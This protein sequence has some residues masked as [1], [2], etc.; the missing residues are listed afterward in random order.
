MKLFDFVD[1]GY[2]LNL[3][4]R[5]DRR[6]QFEAHFHEMGLL[7]GIHRHPATHVL[8]LISSRTGD[9]FTYEQRLQIKDKD[10]AAHACWVSHSEVIKLAKQQGL[11]NVLVLED[12]AMFCR[13]DGVTIVKNA[14]KQLANFPNWEVVYLGGNPD[15]NDLM[16]EYEWVSPNLVRINGTVG[17]HAVIYNARIYDQFIHDVDSFDDN[18][19]ISPADVYLNQTFKEKYI[20]YPMVVI[21][22]GNT[23]SD[24]SYSTVGWNI[25]EWVK[26]YSKLEAK[27]VKKF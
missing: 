8:D 11:E 14:L 9:K 4:H 25:D 23:Y 24:V 22:R 16:G 18:N 6:V 19:P 15:P 7:A 21:Q 27:L 10:L 26:M 1:K 5:P 2:Y 3:N 20:I 12:D 13:L 17:S